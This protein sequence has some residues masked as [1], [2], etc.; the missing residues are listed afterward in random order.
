LCKFNK[1]ESK[2]LYECYLIA[3]QDVNSSLQLEYQIPVFYDLRIDRNNICHYTDQND[4]LYNEKLSLLLDRIKNIPSNVKTKI[5]RNYK[6][7]LNNVEK[8][9]KM[10][11]PKTIV[12]TQQAIDEAD[13]FWDD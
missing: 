8:H 9:I 3:L 4:Q 13:D 12:P 6:T 10:A 5:D 7:L 1:I 2:K 11:V